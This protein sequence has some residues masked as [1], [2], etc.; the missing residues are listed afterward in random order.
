M[1]TKVFN[2]FGVKWTLNTGPFTIKEHVVITL[3]ANVTVGYAY[4]TDALLALQGKPFYDINFGWGVCLSIHSQLAAHRHIHSGNVSQVPGLALR[5][6]V[7]KPVLQDES[8]P[9]TSR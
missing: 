3:M 2:T 7:A 1:P 8:V 5:H 6:D 4:S 9:R